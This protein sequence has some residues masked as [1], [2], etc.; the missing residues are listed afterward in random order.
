MCSAIRGLRGS[1]WLGEQKSRGD[2]KQGGMFSFLDMRREAP[3]FVP[4]VGK[5]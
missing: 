3:S 1:F 4:L 5:P 2:Q